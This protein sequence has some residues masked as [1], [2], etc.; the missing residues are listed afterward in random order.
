VQNTDFLCRR[1]EAA[2]SVSHGLATVVEKA[3]SQ[4]GLPNASAD[5]ARACRRLERF[6]VASAASMNRLIL[7]VA[8]A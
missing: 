7:L 4:W 5:G 6:S 3:V 8:S 2:G 1:F